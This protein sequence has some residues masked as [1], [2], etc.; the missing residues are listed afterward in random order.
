MGTFDLT[1]QV[2]ENRTKFKCH[3]HVVDPGPDVRAIHD[4]IRLWFR[5]LKAEDSDF[6]RDIRLS[7]WR[8]RTA[9]IM[10]LM[11]FNLSGPLLTDLLAKLLAGAEALPALRERRPHIEHH[12]QRL[13]SLSGNPKLTAMMRLLTEGEVSFG[14]TVGLVWS[15]QGTGLPGWDEC[16]DQELKGRRAGLKVITS[17]K[18]LMSE[19]FE[20]LVLPWGG[21]RCPFLRELHHCMRSPRL[22]VIRY[23]F[24]PLH[25]PERL[26][27]RLATTQPVNDVAFVNA[28]VDAASTT[29]LEN[30]VVMDE[31]EYNDLWSSLRTPA[32]HP[33]SGHVG[34]DR[35][36]LTN[37]RTILFVNGMKAFLREELRVLEV[38]SALDSKDESTKGFSRVP[39]SELA[40]GNLV[41]LRTSGGQDFLIEVADQLMAAAGDGDLRSRAF[42]WKP[43]LR[44]A[45]ESVGSAAIVGRLAQSGHGLKSGHGYIW[46]WTTADFVKPESEAMFYEMMAIL[47]DLGFTLKGGGALA[48]S[49]SRWAAMT[50]IFGYH[51]SAGHVIRRL[52]MGKLQELAASGV[53]ISSELRLTLPQ[54]GAG[55]LTVLRVAE[56]DNKA[57]QVPYNQTG[58]LMNAWR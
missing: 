17:L 10:G 33:G 7:L 1:A 9:A 41:I 28:P 27:L 30:R 29:T 35:V 51:I 21:W 34:G 6:I 46:Y 22:D 5:E 37:A 52:L 55:E 58:I 36:F 12:V 50:R 44:E 13:V 25:V 8:L 54:S 42:D 32:F 49:E 4:E 16:L 3:D 39:V 31:Q 18:Q 23:S 11:P 19:T 2:F 45:L 43:P 24:E 47:E 15:A 56:V 14:S 38:S 20:M 40:P 57:I 53:N 48:A 26:Q